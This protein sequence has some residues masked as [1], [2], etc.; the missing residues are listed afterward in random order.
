MKFKVRED[1]EVGKYYEG[2]RFDK[3]RSRYAGM[4]IDF[5]GSRKYLNKY[6]YNGWV[7]SKEMLEPAED[8][9]MEVTKSILLTSPP[10]T[11]ISA[12]IE[13]K[14]IFDPVN[15]PQH[16]ADRKYEVIDVIQDSMSQTEF[17]G[18]LRGNVLKYVMRY[19]KKGGVQ[20]LEKGEFYLKRLIDAEKEKANG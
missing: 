4:V 6:V 20:D 3:D 2:I 17:K 13:G 7:F 9:E 19:D 1:L 11:M 16:Y 10:K 8:E 18:F 15:K 12:A 14:G 5:E